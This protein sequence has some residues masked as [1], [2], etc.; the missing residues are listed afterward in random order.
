MKL[1]RAPSVPD[2][3][4]LTVIVLLS[5][6]IDDV[7]PIPLPTTGTSVGTGV[8]SGFTVGT[9]AIVGRAGDVGFGVGL[10]DG[11]TVTD[12]AFIPSDTYIAPLLSW[13]P[14]SSVNVIVTS[15]V[16]AVGSE[17][18]IVTSLLSANVTP[19]P[20]IS[21]NPTYKIPSA[22]FVVSDCVDADS[23]FTLSV[24]TPSGTVIAIVKLLRAPSVPTA[25]ALTVIVLLSFEISALRSIPFASAALTVIAENI[26]N[27]IAKA[28]IKEMIFLFFILIYS[29]YLI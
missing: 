23:A 22:T 20:D 26:V 11:I 15:S 18:V 4:A 10:P 16:R 9:G 2:A 5:L 25:V 6:E 13:I 7:R 14:A 21:R 17:I 27:I 24:V 3:V 8:T 12:E 19:L 29:F 28:Q 1:L